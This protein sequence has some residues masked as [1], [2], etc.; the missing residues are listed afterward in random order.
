MATTKGSTTAAPIDDSANR[1]EIQQQ[2]TTALGTADTTSAQKVNTLGLIYKARLSRLN[3]AVTAAVGQY[4]ADSTQ[5]K[6]AKDAVTAQSLT[7]SRVALLQKQQSTPTPQ[8]SAT[9]WVLQGRVY[10]SQLQPATRYTVFLVDSKKIFQETY[11]FAYTDDSGYFLI[12]YAGTTAQDGTAP[13]QLYIEVANPKAQPVY[14]S[15]TA[16]SPTLGSTTYQNITLPEEERPLGNPP[17]AIR[18]TALP[19]GTT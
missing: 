12:N 1:A 6:Q 4:G 18:K 3:R 16:F 9:G 17:E 10:N 8:V 13:P 2:I 7:I 14:L 15:T 5:A 19:E 11:S